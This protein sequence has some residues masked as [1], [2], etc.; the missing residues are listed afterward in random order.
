MPLFVH[1]DG[2]VLIPTARSIWERLLSARPEFSQSI[3]SGESVAAYEKVRDHAVQQGRQQYRDVQSVLQQRIARE[4]ER[5]DFAFAAR[6]RAVERIGLPEV[7]N[8]RL[9]R[10]E[11]EERIWRDQLA[12]QARVVP[13]LMAITLVRVS[14]G[15]PNG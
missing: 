9:A 10:L 8:F 14:G 3:H 1:D 7:R 5:G 15:N 13:E 2:R 6:R 11:Q 12:G 4:R